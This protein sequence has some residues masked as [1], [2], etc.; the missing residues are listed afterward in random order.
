MGMVSDCLMSETANDKG[1]SQF[2]KKIQECGH[3]TLVKA[4][5]SGINDVDQDVLLYTC[6]SCGKSFTIT[7]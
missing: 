4:E 5:R 6:P 3:P 2:A 1:S 7:E